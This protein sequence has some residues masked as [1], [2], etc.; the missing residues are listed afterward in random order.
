MSKPL[1]DQWRA[2]HSP[3]VPNEEEFYLTDPVSILNVDDDVDIYHPN[4][5]LGVLRTIQGKYN[6]I[7]FF[8]KY[9]EHNILERKGETVGYGFPPYVFYRTKKTL[10]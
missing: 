10:E 3:L 7:R 9:N 4:G 8:F 1:L 5:D 6:P 2:L